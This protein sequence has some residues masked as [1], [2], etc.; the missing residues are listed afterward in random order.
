MTQV[1]GS[2]NHTPAPHAAA[3]TGRVLMW[4]GGSVWIS[5]G[6]GQVAPHAHHAIQLTL[7]P[8]HP[9]RIRSGNSGEWLETRAAIIRHDRTHQIDGGGHDA[10]II[11]IEPETRVGRA[12]AGRCGERDI[13][14]TAAPAIQEGA[15][16][17]L[18]QFE[19]DAADDVLVTQA[20]ALAQLFAGQPEH[21][22]IVD[23]RITRALEWIQDHL[24]DELSLS[25]VAATT[26]L[27]P[28][29]FRHLFV[30]QT[31]ISFRAYV[32][33]AR[34]N[35]A[36]VL[37]LSGT[38]WTNAA[39]EVGFADAAHLSRTFRRMFGFAPT[40]LGKSE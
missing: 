19:A 4:R 13:T 32:L 39:Q 26:H 8:G 23:P 18:D 6:T 35:Q 20:Q 17:L 14:V 5:R 15:R 36:V 3:S 40:M 31:G 22:A 37:G 1:L 11:F 2:L 28:G 34:V 12:I 9:I 27:S 33:W 21:V 24:G 10:L 29:R 16:E 38:S 30:A 7:A 25:D